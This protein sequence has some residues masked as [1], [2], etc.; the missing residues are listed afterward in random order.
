MIRIYDLRT[1]YR[2]GP[3]VLDCSNP[4]FSWKL[5]SDKQGVIQKEYCIRV[6]NGQ[7]ELWNS[8]RVESSKSQRI[9]YEGGALLS[10][11]EL[12][13]QVTV[14]AVD[15]NGAEE[16][17]LSETAAL[18][19]GLLKEE[20]WKARW[21]EPE[22]DVDPDARKPA[23]Y[24]RKSFHV[25]PGL[26]K[27]FIYQT[28]HG[29]Y[30]FWL[31]GVTGTKDRFKPGFTSYYSRIQYQAYEV[32]DL[33]SPGENVWAAVLG[34][35]WWRG[36]TGGTVVNNFGKK[37]QFLGQLEL[38]YE[39]GTAET[40]VSDEGFKTGYGGLEASDMLMGDVYDAA[41]EPDGW[42][43]PGFD[44]SAWR[45]VHVIDESDRRGHTDARRIAGGLPVREKEEF[46]PRVF[47]DASGALILDFGQNIAGYV[48]MC[49]H[50][51]TKGQAVTL[52][53]AETL[54]HQGNFTV[55]NVNKCSYPVKAFQQVQYHCSGKEEESYCP[56]FSIFGFRYVKIEGYTEEIRDGDFTAVAVYTD[57]EETG[58]FTCSNPLINQLV[59]N[60]RWSQKGNFMD[61]PVDC[62]TRERNSWTGDCQIFVRTASCFMNVYPFFEKCLTDMALEQFG[63]GKIG[64]TFPSTSSVHDPEELERMK[65]LNPLSALAGPE[66]NGS[67]G[68]DCAGW[69]DA[70]AWIPY[71]LYLCYGDKKILE[72]QYETARRWV[73]Y[74]LACAKEHN[75][76]YE[77][78][79]MYHTITDGELDADYIYDTKMHYGEWQE[80]IAKPSA[81]PE[82]TNAPKKNLADIFALMVK[83]GKPKVAT[84]YMCR[85][86][87]NV[88]FMAEVLGK[89]TEAEKY[90]KT[91]EKIRNMYEKYLIDEDGCIEPGHQAAY[92]RA[93]A[94][95]LSTGKKRKL[96]EEQL[97]K[98][99]E[100]NGYRLNTGFLSTPFLLPTLAEMGRADLAYRILEQT[101]MPSWLYSVTKGA[102]TIPESWD[103]FDALNDS[104]NHYSYGAVCEFLFAYV[105][106]IRPCFE[107]PGYEEF[108]L[109]PILG[110]SL[111][112]A[113]A[114]Y[115]SLY[116]PIISEW[117]R[118]GDRY[119]YQC[120][121][122]ANTKARLTLPDG[123][124]HILG[125]G[126]YQYTGVTRNYE[127]K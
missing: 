103:G 56:M 75:P 57:M 4:R 47:K 12:F 92:V 60:S 106:G 18:S 91:A 118:E 74:M 49:L 96:V 34:D 42:K 51:C 66:G 36:V 90:L 15:E 29:L 113:R 27:A 127:K 81:E 55:A 19:M 87:D 108:E 115:V 85:S 46:S 121:V 98:E 11:M 97:I 78:L 2:K 17:G 102:T 100:D 65:R 114:E 44:D 1:E 5:E 82:S 88:A 119:F 41:K 61:V 58:D 77:P 53:H 110:G 94:M 99:I 123:K 33:L 59:K 116:G 107:K 3:V 13:W 22:G 67:I 117:R 111:T 7:E 50:G 35:G 105:A 40:V 72:N 112:E 120:T 31:N 68:E 125:S 80:P 79:P 109:H 104:L 63:S 48:R 10:R 21:I 54:D 23:P 43:K 30:E 14:K 95:N 126:T 76:I 62:P 64:I 45:Q 28:A 83:Y 52:T 32:T 70:A 8:G 124:F 25:R 38:Y 24:L 16:T 20:D 71:M 101:E 122:P 84:A 93:L 9:L 89:Q 86:A 37:L 26:K 39:D 6:W 69:G 73:D